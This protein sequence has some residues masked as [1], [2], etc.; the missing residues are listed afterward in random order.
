[1]PLEAH[2]MHTEV[3]REASGRG[4]APGK[5]GPACSGGRG[6]ERRF[7]QAE[8][9]WSHWK[10]R[11]GV[12]GEASVTAR[13]V[14]SSAAP[15]RPVHRGP[16]SGFLAPDCEQDEVVAPSLGSS[17]SSRRDWKRTLVP[18]RALL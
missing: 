15:P 12:R 18:E 7:P 5:K 2:D 14:R 11:E 10:L 4:G 6:T 13:P 8:G 1:M 16:L 9:S 3:P 17:V